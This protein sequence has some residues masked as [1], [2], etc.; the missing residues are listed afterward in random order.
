MRVNDLL[1]SAGLQAD[2]FTA[3]FCDSYAAADG[4]T[5]VMMVGRLRALGRSGKV[6]RRQLLF[7]SGFTG[8]K[9]LA[10]I[11]GGESR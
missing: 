7:I 4:L 1:A 8:D 5:Q 2:D 9:E 10:D 3:G 6:S 11:A